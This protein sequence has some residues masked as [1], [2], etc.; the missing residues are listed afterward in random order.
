MDSR[1]RR[2][3]G[4]RLQGCGM[5]ELHLITAPPKFWAVVDLARIGWGGPR[6]VPWLDDQP[7]VILREVEA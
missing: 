1:L 7:V 5:T 4:K 2:P 6:M 3:V